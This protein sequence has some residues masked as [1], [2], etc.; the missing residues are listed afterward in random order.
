MNP[1]ANADGSSDITCLYAHFKHVH[2]C[3][4]MFKQAEYIVH[5]CGL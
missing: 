5:T 2:T 1:A 4:Y 3:T